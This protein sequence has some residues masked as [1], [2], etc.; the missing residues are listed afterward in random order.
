MA[1]P[2]KSVAVQ[3]DRSLNKDEI[4]ARTRIEEKIK[5]NADKLK[6]P[7]YL[8]SSQKKIFKFI[9]D[10]LKSSDILGNLDIYVLTE[11][12]ICIDRMQEIEKRINARPESI[13]SPT[14]TAAKDK[15]TKA[16]FRYCNEL[17]LSPQSRAKMANINS[18][19]QKNEENPLLKLLMEDD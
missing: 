19:T 4:A 13:D 6:P 8:T 10:N 5:G 11:C 9:L 12:S 1:R 3:A 2:C 18:Q 17:C 14:L 7:K 15:Y 16:F